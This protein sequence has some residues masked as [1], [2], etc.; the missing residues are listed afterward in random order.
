[1]KRFSPGILALVMFIAPGCQSIT[2]NRITPVGG[3]SGSPGGEIKTQPVGGLPI[4]VQVPSKAIFI[5]TVTRYRVTRVTPAIPDPATADVTGG[6]VEVLPDE[7]KTE[8][9]KDPIFLG[10]PELYALDVKRPAFGTI[11]YTVDLKD[12]YPTKIGAKI[13]DKTLGEITKFLSDT[14]SKLAGP[15]GVIKQS[16]EQIQREVVD[17]RVKLVIF[18]LATGKVEVVDPAA[19]N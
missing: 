15:G 4:V 9:S 6:V 12:Y 19:P 11:D 1:M 13:D 3:V 2:A 5:A 14:L 16:G 10:R 18:D 17:Q 8:I 7:F